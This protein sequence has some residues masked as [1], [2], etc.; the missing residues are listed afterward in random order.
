MGKQQLFVD[1]RQYSSVEPAK[2]DQVKS[3]RVWKRIVGRL[4]SL[5]DNIWAIGDEIINFSQKFTNN[6]SQETKFTS[7]NLYFAC[8]WV[9]IHEFASFFDVH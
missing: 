8:L 3:D 7:K 1:A 6:P 2:S 5:S 9:R 4:G